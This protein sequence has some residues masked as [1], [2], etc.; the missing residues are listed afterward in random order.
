M[1]AGFIEN[2]FDTPSKR[3]AWAVMA[4]LTIVVLA[5]QLKLPLPE[6]TGEKGSTPPPPPP[7]PKED[8]PWPPGTPWYLQKHG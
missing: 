5:E 4:V 1:N 3:I 7:P 8:P 6:P 2:W